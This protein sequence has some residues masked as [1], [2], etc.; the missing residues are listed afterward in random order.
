LRWHPGLAVLH[1]FSGADLR[2]LVESR[3]LPSQGEEAFAPVLGAL[4]DTAETSRL[5]RSV[6]NVPVECIG[7]NCAG[8]IEQVI[9]HHEQSDGPWRGFALRSLADRADEAGAILSSWA[10]LRVQGQQH[11]ASRRPRHFSTRP[12]SA[13]ML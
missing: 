11:F 6:T 2:R 5:V 9:L 13:T 4:V 12:E 7:D 1:D 8:W 3:I 10:A